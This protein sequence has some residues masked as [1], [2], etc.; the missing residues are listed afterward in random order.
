MLTLAQEEKVRLWLDEQTLN[1]DL[2]HL[3][4]WTAQYNYAGKDRWDIT[5]RSGS[6]SFEPPKALVLKTKVGEVSYD[7]YVELYLTDLNLSRAL[8]KLMA[9]NKVTVVCLCS[10]EGFCHRYIVAIILQWF[11]AKYKGERSR[12]YGK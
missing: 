8:L 1:A 10:G 11:G 12:P 3:E 5:M 4:F 9:K 6:S 7:E 2:S